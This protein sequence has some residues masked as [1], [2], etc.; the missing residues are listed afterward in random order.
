MPV[1]RELTLMPGA[2]TLLSLLLATLAPAQTATW[3][4]LPVSQAPNLQFA[5]GN[6]RASAA[7]DVARQRVVLILWNNGLE[8]WELQGNQW[9]LRQVLPPLAGFVVG[10]SN[11]V[12]DEVRQ[13]VF[14]TLITS[15][16][17]QTG[18]WDGTTW[19]PRTSPLAPPDPRL[20]LV[21]DPIRQ[22]TVLVTGLLVPTA[23]AWDGQNW[24]PIAAP[25]QNGPLGFDATRGQIVCLANGTLHAFDGV[26]WQNLGVVSPAVDGQFVHDP[27]L[28]R[29]LILSFVT[30]TDV[31]HQWNG[32]VWDTVTQIDRP[33]FLFPERA[34]TFDPTRA[35]LVMVGN[36]AGHTTWLLQEVS[37]NSAAFVPFGAGC[38]NAAGA[39]VLR[40]RNLPVIGRTL[41]LE[42]GNVATGALAFGL[43]G[44]STTSWGGQALPL[45]LAPL[46]GPGC[47]LYLAPADTRTLTVAGGSANWSQPIPLALPLIGVT[48]FAQA[49]AVV[50]TSLATSNAAQV[51]IG[52]H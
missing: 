20:R 22:R 17:W 30:G 6:Q 4:E 26:A 28:Q 49:G 47:R 31:V 8:T 44:T 11:L 19:T 40:A 52:P 35:A 13:R 12:W 43:L 39:P 15:V 32:T 34:M 21:R 24:S 7:W 10:W 45:D 42:V 27:L 29:L 41:E 25:P 5:I 23:F 50:G 37:G 18:E 33:P 2:R 16:G 46:G 14:F 38:Q 3:S 48:V 1:R 9:Q 51:L 36:L